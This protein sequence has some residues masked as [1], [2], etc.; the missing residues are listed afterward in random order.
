MA[1]SPDERAFF[2]QLGARIAKLRKAQGITQVQMAGTLGVSQQ[3]VNSYEVARRR[4]P[5]SALP[6]LARLLSM[7]ID[8]LLGETSK[9]ANGKRGPAS[10][11]QQQIEQ[12]RQLPRT[13]Q[14][15]VSKMLETV[16]QQAG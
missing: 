4:I 3:T 13:Q 5:V 2:I 15:F 10:K 6:I 16:I 14:T 9:P 11:L 8:E 1:I 7:S 12:I